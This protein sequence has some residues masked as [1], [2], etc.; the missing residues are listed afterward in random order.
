MP[1]T[2]EYGL[3]GP[4]TVH[5]DGLP[6]ALPRRQRELL[7]ALLLSAGRVVSV[8]ALLVT[9]WG[10]APPPTA[11]ASLHNHVKR[12]RSVLDAGRE[13]AERRLLTEP[14]GYLLRLGADV[15]DVT[16]AET[17]LAA[18]RS[19]ARAEDWAE[20]CELAADAL[21]LWRGEPLADLGSDAL[22]REAPRLSELRLQVWETR[23]E[24]QMHLGRNAEVISELR[25]LAQEHP[26]REQLHGLLM[27]ALYR[28][29]RRAEALAVYRAARH[30]LV[31]E[32]GSEP[33]PELQ[34]LHQEILSDEP[35][36]PAPAPTAVP[37]QLP[38]PVAGFVGRES[39]LAGLTAYLDHAAHDGATMVISAIG[40]T[41]GVGKTALAVRWAHSAAA[42]FPD[43]QL[44]VNLRGYDPQD[45]V[46]ADDA[47][48]GFLVALG[49]AAP[50]IPA[51]RG[52]RIAAYRSLLADRRVLIVLDNAR[53]LEQ[54]RPLLPGAP[55]CAVLVTSREAL[56]GLVARDGAVRLDLDVLAPNAAAQLLRELIGERARRDEAAA[57]MLAELCCGLPLALRIAAEL[58][59]LRPGAELAEIAEDLADSRHRLDAFDA[60]GDEA[61]AIRA[62]F[63]WSY[64]TLEPEVARAFRLGAL[65]PGPAFDAY[66]AAALL[67]TD[68]PGARRL[69]DR[70]ARAYLVQHAGPG[71]YAMHDLLRAYARELAA[72]EESEAERRAALTRLFDLYLHTAAQ[73]ADAL[74]PA[75]SSR[76]PAVAAPPGPIPRVANPSAATAWLDAERA[77]LVATALHATGFGWPDH[78]TRLSVILYRYLDAEGHF[79]EAALVHT[80]ARRAAALL[81]DVSAEAAALRQLASVDFRQ[82][83]FAAAAD[84][85]NL[86]LSLLAAVGDTRGQTHTVH[87]LGLVERH[88]G[89]FLDAIG[90]LR[91]ALALN[92][93]QGDTLGVARTLMN[94]AVTERSLGQFGPAVEHLTE[95]LVLYRELRDRMGRD[96]LTVAGEADALTNLGVVDLRLGHAVQAADRHRQAIALYRSVE[97]QRGLVEAMVNLG[98]AER[99]QGLYPMAGR[100]L[101]QAVA[102]CRELGDR[103]CEA[104]AHANLGVVYLRDGRH[105]QAADE[106]RLALALYRDLGDQAGL[107]QALESLGQARAAVPHGRSG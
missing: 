54:I 46:D 4:V 19:A 26:L 22:A 106:L 33:T 15:L 18:A 87:N 105:P 85:L 48:A 57:R 17:L 1:E 16:R 63:S 65:H 49:V 42:R 21:A 59:A 88:Q 32:L 74:F 29:G 51:G 23:L 9:L 34:R 30:V 69:L 14:G 96:A 11:R 80:Q 73:C 25:A 68:L 8:E 5:C 91:Q 2:V 45:P 102:L 44:Y 58:A 20:T 27:L 84:Q 10:A 98:A 66:A 62:V 76:R 77:N 7:A 31:S 53:R 67:G 101:E 55:G 71:R 37:R 93:A 61:S 52:E 75:E 36:A 86:A 24:A 13:P 83:R 50:R 103:Y 35:A 60:G 89:R 39:E 107:A 78:T 99:H 81:A 6:A 100:H 40:G 43:G 70:L 92:R 28:C 56:G 38:P 12:L 41:A 94:L 95:S 104:D 79:S 47:L 64:R 82:G 97:D 3:L 90:H 72:A